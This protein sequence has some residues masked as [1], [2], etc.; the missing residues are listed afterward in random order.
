MTAAADDDALAL[1]W[2]IDR[3][4]RENAFGLPERVETEPTWEAV[5]FRLGGVN[6]LS[7]M[8]EVTEL[9]SPPRLTAV[10]G[11]QDWV[12]GIANVRGNLL[13]VMDLAGFLG[14]SAV[15]MGRRTRV[16]V[17]R[18]GA[19]AAGLLVDEVL[20]IMHLREEERSAEAV[21]IGGRAAK[22]LRGAYRQDGK[23]WGVFTMQ[24]VLESAEFIEVA[25]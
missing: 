4:S 7:S 6:F 17:V 2:A 24:G 3:R 14:F 10:P 8:E 21:H 15:R 16:L 11:A 18:S 9:L 13:P 5:G 1:L 22:F 12:K 25:L 23:L 20:G 19:L